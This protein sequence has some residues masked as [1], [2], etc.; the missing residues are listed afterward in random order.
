MAITKLNSL[1]IPPDTIVESDLS[2]PLTNFS[3]TG[4]DDNATSNAITIDASENV[5]IGATDP[6]DAGLVVDAKGEAN[7]SASARFKSNVDTYLRIA[8]FGTGSDSTITLGNNYN[9]NGGG[10]SADNSAYPTH[11]ITLHTDGSMRFGTGAA[12][13]TT[14]TERMRIDS[15]GNVGIG[16]NSPDSELDVRGI[17]LGGA[18]SPSTGQIAFGVQYGGST[19]IANTYGT[20]KSSAAT[21][22]GWGV[23][24]SP[25]VTEGFVS[26]VDT[27]LNFRR[28]ALLVDQDE[29]RFLNAGQQ[30]L[31][32]DAAVT[33]TERFK[34]DASGNVLIGVTSPVGTSA[35]T[36]E[37]VTLKTDWSWFSH[38][39]AVYIHR[40][41]GGAGNVLAFYR[42]SN[43]CGGVSVTSSN[44]T[45]FNTSSD[46]RLKENAVS[47]NGAIERIKQIPVYRF[48]FI[49]DPDTTVDGFIA[50]EVADIVPEAVTGEKDAMKTEEYEITPAV[51]DDMKNIVESA[52]MGTRE[53]PDYQ[54]IDQ[55][56]LVPLL[57]KAIQEQQVM[58]EALQA[59]VTALK[60]AP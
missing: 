49:S 45:S 5:G 21:C 46:Y 14:P 24:G 41:S 4:I 1:A 30:T 38:D 23:Y 60:E 55:S 29:L 9:R 58:I 37:S 13:S 6:S 57:T 7:T 10:F 53:V 18:N 40:P 48:N 15:S 12:G 39:D 59:E 22:I 27:S 8:R 16:A 33:M 17:V 31:A 25:S 32:R 35:N 47:L 34:V 20:M 2:Y 28:G 26:S 44:T 56:K 50:H 36:I 43:Y 51:L 52:V 54:C 19:N 3:S 42:G 11:N